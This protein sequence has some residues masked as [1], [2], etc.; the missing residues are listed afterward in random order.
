M[1]GEDRLENIEKMLDRQAQD[2]VDIK[3]TLSSIA[4]QDQRLQTLE[5]G[6]DALWLKYD[7]L[8]APE[9]VIQNMKAFQASC[10]RATIRWVWVCL[11]PMALT[12]VLVAIGLFKLIW[13]V[14]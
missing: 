1:S 7:E 8:A 13:G 14:Q 2:L 6:C 4:V 9:G 5:K 3:T 10:P 11:V 12:Q